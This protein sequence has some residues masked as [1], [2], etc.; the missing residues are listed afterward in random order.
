MKTHI[1]KTHILKKDAIYCHEKPQTL[2]G[3]AGWALSW[4][5]GGLEDEN[6]NVRCKGCYNKRF[7]KYRVSGAEL[8][9]ENLN[10][11]R[12]YVATFH[13]AYTWRY[14]WRQC[15]AKKFK[16]LAAFKRAVAP[17]LR[18]RVVWALRGFVVGNRKDYRDVMRQDPF[19]DERMIRQRM[20]GQISDSDLYGF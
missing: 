1:L 7:P 2:C 18:A 10:A 15:L 8:S 17:N 12:T 16:G 5:D 3:R 4:H 20:S 6:G 9:Q 19:P 13:A 14:V 11:L